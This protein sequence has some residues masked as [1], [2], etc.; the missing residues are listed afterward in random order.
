MWPRRSSLPSTEDEATSVEGASSLEV[1]RSIVEVLRVDESEHPYMFSVD[2]EAEYRAAIT[3]K[4]DPAIELDM[5][6]IVMPLGIPERYRGVEGWW[7]FWFGWLEEWED[8]RFSAENWEVRGEHVIF[9]VDIATRGRSSGVPVGAF[10]AHVWSIRSG[11]LRRVRIFPS[12]ERAV[13]AA[14]GSGG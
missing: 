6:A 13:A 2:R 12:H 4:L 3:P 14:E 1:A 8:Y 9:D 11:R 7:G 5:T 10:I